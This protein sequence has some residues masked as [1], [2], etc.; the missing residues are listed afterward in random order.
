MLDSLF[1]KGQRIARA[2]KPL[3]VV[4][5]IKVI[6]IYDSDKGARVYKFGKVG[7]SEMLLNLIRERYSRLLFKFVP[8]IKKVIDENPS[9]PEIR[10]FAAYALGE[11]AKLDI[12]YVL[13]EAIE[14]LAQHEN[15]SSRAT[16]GYFFAYLFISQEK[17]AKEIQ[18]YLREV[19]SRW[20]YSG[21][22][23][24]KWA[25]A[26]ICEQ[27]GLF[28]NNEVK[29][30]AKE[31]LEKLASI[32]DIRVANSV[33]HALVSWSL[34]KQ[35][36]DSLNLIR[37]WCEQ[38]SA[39]RND[40][41]NPHQV[42][43]VVGIWAFGAIVIRNS[44]LLGKNSVND[45]VQPIELTKTVLEYRKTPDDLLPMMTT[46]AVRSFEYQMGNYFFIMLEKWADI[47]P[48]SNALQTL[49]PI[50]LRKIYA[51]LPVNSL[52]RRHIENRI[53]NVWLKSKNPKLLAIAKSMQGN[54]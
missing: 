22:W 47:A 53:H 1:D 34:K 9:N 5:T 17:I 19:L 24:L 25:A 26:S 13:K 39:G 45:Y 51:N 46:V 16:V 54:S 15:S 10:V 35:L 2:F 50:W 37:K 18:N 20:I 32:D 36:L 48:D 49:I 52:H 23:R 12:R 44:E 43:C 7:D 21:G 29:Q 3:P 6:E 41:F 28:G 38:G 33:I 8:I 27:L 30:L 11:I 42:R 40:Q 14:P 31:S 4:A